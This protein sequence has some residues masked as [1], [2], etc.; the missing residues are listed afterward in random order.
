[1][2]IHFSKLELV[3]FIENSNDTILIEELLAVVKS[4]DQDIWQSL[5]EHQKD[6]IELGIKQLDQG[7]RISLDDFRKKHSF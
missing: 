4:S 6:E 3:K 1:M 7:N 2:D 5:S